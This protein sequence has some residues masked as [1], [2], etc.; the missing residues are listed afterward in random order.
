MRT[1]GAGA[2]ARAIAMRWRW[3][4]ENEPGYS[5]ARAGSMP[6]SVRRLAHASASL[7]PAR[8]PQRVQG[9]GYGRADFHPRIQGGERVLEDGLD[10]AAQR[11]HRELRGGTDSLVIQQ[12]LA[13]VW[14]EKPE[15]HAGERRLATARLADEG[16]RLTRAHL[17]ADVVQT[18]VA[19]RV[20][21]G[22]A[23]GAQDRLTHGRSLHY[24]STRPALPRA[25][26]PRRARGRSGSRGGRHRCARTR[27][28]V[29]ARRTR[30]SVPSRRA[31]SVPCG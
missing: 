15:K 2:S 30:W 31:C 9:F 21:E 24:R 22:D 18:S 23:A 27:S 5:P 1:R 8:N 3:P 16:E 17:D 13:C 7:L 12:H 4:P 28:R 25:P 26:P 20:S 11:A 10:A 19:A 14:S 29:R 6:T